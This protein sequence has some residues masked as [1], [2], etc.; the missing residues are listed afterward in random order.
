MNGKLITNHLFS[1]MNSY[2]KIA[3]KYDERYKNE[4]LKN[5]VN[6]LNDV[7]N[8]NN[9]KRIIEIGC[10]TGH[11]LQNLSSKKC[12]LFGL[13]FSNGMLKQAKLKTKSTNFVC[14]D[15]N[16]I[17]FLYNTFDFIFLVNA[18]HQ[19]KNKKSFIKNAVSLLKPGGSF[20][21]IGVFP[22]SLDYEW[23]VYD[24][25][26][27]V[28]KFDLKRFPTLDKLIEMLQQ[29]NL[30]NI[31]FQKIY[32]IEKTHFD[33]D[34]FNDTFLQKDGCSQMTMLSNTKYEEGIIRIKK[35]VDFMN[36]QKKKASFVTKIQYYIVSGS[37]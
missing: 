28:Y 37:K 3:N 13:D 14:A 8:S 15:A 36:A 9:Y 19:F 34:V 5:I 33:A 35:H 21:V 16:Q 2:N 10:G 4:E 32:T 6:N 29:Q 30:S 24:F 7:I 11:W 27:S 18:L 31:E 1:V 26:P 22:A 25:F 12:K 23:Y 17:P 20:A